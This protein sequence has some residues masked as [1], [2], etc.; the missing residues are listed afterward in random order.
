[1][2]GRR[3]RR[4][5]TIAPPAAVLA[6]MA[7]CAVA[8]AAAPANDNRDAAQ[9]LSIPATVTGT[10]NESTREQSEPPG[11]CDGGGGTVWYRLDV[12]ATGT[13]H[14]DV[15]A[16]GDL[17]AGV[18]IFKRTRSQLSSIGCDRTDENGHASPSADVKAG[19]SL[20]IRVSQL[21]N[22]VPG[23]FTLNV[24]FE[25]PTPGAPGRALPRAG[26]SGRLTPLKPADAWSTRM[27]AGQPYRINISSGATG[28]NC[29]RAD[30]FPPGT[31]DFDEASPVARIGCDGYRVFTPGPRQGGRYSMLVRTSRQAKQ[32]M[33]YHVQVAAAGHDDIAPGVFIRNYAKVRGSVDARGIDVVDLYRFDVVRRSKLDLGLASGADVT[34]ELRRDSGRVIDRS[35]GGEEIQTTLPRGRYFAVVRATAGAHG[36]YTL[37]RVSRAITHTSIGVD[38]HTHRAIAPG[39]SAQ[40]GVT[41]KPA[42]GGPATV[43]VERFDPVEGWRFSQQFE[44][45]LSGGRATVSYRPPA[46]GRYRVRAQFKGTRLAS[47]SASRYAFVT[48]EGPLVEKVGAASSARTGTAK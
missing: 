47:G 20:L 30:V 5:A 42:T 2:P 37:R 12:P 10:T 31:R 39:R 3:N 13:V 41:V 45:Q 38:G 40:I 26:T 48:V 29:P 14:V 16:A 35:S 33:A 7:V 44:R 1:M 15:Q 6:A 11:G 36:R 8:L 32:A 23:D 17:D 18:D 22:S 34:L 9:Q 25:A 27:T 19:D 21:S 46:V 43:I 4:I 28:G 24:Q